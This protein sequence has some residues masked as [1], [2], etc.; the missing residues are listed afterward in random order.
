MATLAHHALAILWVFLWLGGKSRTEGLGM[1]FSICPICG[2][3]SLDRRPC[4]RCLG[5]LW[6]KE[7]EMLSVGMREEAAEELETLMRKKEVNHKK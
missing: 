7:D 4:Y 6:D 2:S 3:T 5:L 1:P